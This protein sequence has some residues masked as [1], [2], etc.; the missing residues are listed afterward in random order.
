MPEHRL[1]KD[2]AVL[3]DRLPVA[4][5]VVPLRHVQEPADL[6]ESL[7][8]PFVVP[9]ESLGGRPGAAKRPKA[10]RDKRRVALQKLAR[11]GVDG[12]THLLERDRAQRHELLAVAF[13]LMGRMSHS[14][15]RGRDHLGVG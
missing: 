8:E 2:P 14:E 5:V 15:E 6:R 11:E 3:T 1:E 4:A 13:Q 12:T 7:R 9:L 10:A